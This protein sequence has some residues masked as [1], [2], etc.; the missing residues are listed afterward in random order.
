MTI[1]ELFPTEEDL[2]LED[3]KYQPELTEKLDVTEGDFNQELLM[4][5]YFGK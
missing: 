3:W 4:K 1:F 2:K 5:L